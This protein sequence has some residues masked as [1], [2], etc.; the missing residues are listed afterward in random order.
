MEFIDR[1]KRESE[2]FKGSR[3]HAILKFRFS[4]LREKLFEITKSLGSCLCIE[5]VYNSQETPC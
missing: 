3:E 5:V 4:K 2:I 1:N